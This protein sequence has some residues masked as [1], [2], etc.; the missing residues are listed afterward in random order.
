MTAP[1][2]L[3]KGDGIGGD[4]GTKSITNAIDETCQSLSPEL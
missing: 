4:M 1:I 2:A 3:I